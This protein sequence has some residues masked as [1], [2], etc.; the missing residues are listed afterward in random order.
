M[1]D[2]V[3]SSSEKDPI[4]P[5][6]Y[7][8]RYDY[9][10]EVY[11]D[12]TRYEGQKRNNMRNGTGTYVFQNGYVYKGN[13]KDDEMHGFGTMYVNGKV[14]YEG[15]WRN[16]HFHGRGL[17]YNLERQEALNQSC[18]SNLDHIHL[19]WDR[20]EGEFYHG[21]RH[22]SGTLFYSNGDFFFGDFK[23]GTIHGKGSYTK[24]GVYKVAAVWENNILVEELMRGEDNSVNSSRLDKSKHI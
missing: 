21:M 8:T 13:W 11:E 7:L 1:R 14:L 5:D 23:N 4:N 20:Y 15:E 3:H 17:L 18:A 9:V 24:P 19:T 6:Q 12:N 22:G 10:D 2:S 16:N